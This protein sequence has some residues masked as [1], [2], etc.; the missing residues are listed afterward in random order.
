M[1]KRVYTLG[2]LQ[3]FIVFLIGLYVES[4]ASNKLLLLE[5]ILR[6]EVTKKVL[7]NSI[8][9]LVILGI[10]NF[11]LFLI[12][13]KDKESQISSIFYNNICQ[14][15]FDGYIKP[16]TTLANADFRVSFFKA[17]K[18]LLFRKQDYCVPK[19]YTYL[20]NVGRYQT[21]QEKKLSKIKFLP[22]EGVVGNCYYVGEFIFMKT[23]IGSDPNYSNEQLSKTNLPK[24]KIKKLNDKSS[25]FVA[26]PI[27]FF[28]SDDIFGVII[29]DCLNSNKLKE[30]EFR[31]IEEVIS[32]YSVFFN[33]NVN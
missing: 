32:N 24:D 31:T 20:I 25:D 13:H 7:D 12:S 8:L 33:D 10:V 23:C 26:C 28:N 2:A 18:G 15:V 5:S 29:V 30:E 21:R 1:I 17:K 22:R 27:K 9:V 3:I 16:N 14:I 19:I 6:P 11:I 4:I